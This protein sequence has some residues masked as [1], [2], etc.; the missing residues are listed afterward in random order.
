[1]P[2]F[3]EEKIKTP[4]D[5]G[6]FLHSSDDVSEVFK[7]PRLAPELYPGDFPSVPCSL[8]DGEKLYSLR[9]NAQSTL[10]SKVGDFDPVIDTST[11]PISLDDYL[12]ARGVS[13]T[14]ERYRSE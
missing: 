1:M 8:L 14:A 2:Q 12:L 13:P 10:E 4:I 11:G 3:S 5:N 6:E 9:W 7:A